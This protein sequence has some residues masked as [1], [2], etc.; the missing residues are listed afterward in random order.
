MKKKSFIIPLF[1]AL[2][3]LQVGCN[4]GTNTP[5]ENAIPQDTIDVTDSLMIEQ[6]VSH[7]WGVDSFQ[8]KELGHCYS[9]PDVYALDEK[10]W[11][12]S[13]SINAVITDILDY[14]VSDSRELLLDWC[15]NTCHGVTFHSDMESGVL[16]IDLEALFVGNKG[17]VWNQWD[18]FFDM[19]DGH[20]IEARKF[21]F[22]AFFRQESYSEFLQS[23]GWY[24]GVHQAVAAGFN[25]YAASTSNDFEGESALSDTIE[26]TYKKIVYDID[27]S[28]ENDTFYFWRES[29]Y[30]AIW[31]SMCPFEPNYSDKCS[32][33]DMVPYMSEEG[34]EMVKYLTASPIQRLLREKEL[35]ESVDEEVA[36]TAKREAEWMRMH[37]EELVVFMAKE[38]DFC[39]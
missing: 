26:K 30:N 32:W 20:Q 6:E 24:E 1:G 21:P 16:H 5:S 12:A 38:P 39:K 33:R 31:G 11:D 22:A 36:K 9:L 3:S 14:Y 4:Q 7:P 35:W 28:Y 18:L 25:E 34:R 2:L 27:Y 23:R 17:D 37:Q 10:N 29:N 15:E 8:F 19:E 13:N